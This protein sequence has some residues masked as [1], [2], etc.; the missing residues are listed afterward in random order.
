MLLI[1]STICIEPLC[2]ALPLPPLF[3]LFCSVNLQGFHGDL[4]E[5]FF[6]GKIDKKSSDLVECAFKS[7]AAAIAIVKPGALYRL[8]DSEMLRCSHPIPL[9]LLLL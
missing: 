4:N 8:V 3:D 9:T 1:Y 2:S 6:V 5:T 7:L